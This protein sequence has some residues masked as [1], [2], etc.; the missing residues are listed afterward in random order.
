EPPSPRTSEP[1]PGSKPLLHRRIVLGVTGSI[2]AYK[3]VLLLRLLQDAGAEV[4]VVLTAAGSRFVGA[5]TFRRLGATVHTDMFDAPG[6]LHVELGRRADVVL[7]APATADVL[8]RL[9]HGRADDLL[10]ATVLCSQGLVAVAP[11]MHPRMWLNPAVQENVEIL[12]QR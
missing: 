12:R 7:V 3:A 9:R 11:A 4:E 8:A 5:A 2:A 1:T 10:T 6:E